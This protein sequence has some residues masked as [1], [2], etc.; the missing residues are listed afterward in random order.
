MKQREYVIILIKYFHLSQ[1]TLNVSILAK[2]EHIR[3]PWAFS[4]WMYQNALIAVPLIQGLINSIYPHDIRFLI[5][6]VA[7]FLPSPRGVKVDGI[8][9]RWWLRAA[10][11]SDPT[12]PRRWLTVIALPSPPVQSVPRNRHSRQ[13][14]SPR[15]AR[16]WA[17][18]HEFSGLVGDCFS[19]FI[20]CVSGV[21]WWIK[22][23]STLEQQQ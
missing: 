19:W 22:I 5:P 13:F 4:R 16:S 2:H 20:G 8:P 17:F 3:D 9:A 6:L 7:S 23:W 1:H 15:N 11:S 12:P 14:L 10:A 18:F 21:V